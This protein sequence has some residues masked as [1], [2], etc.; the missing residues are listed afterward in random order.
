MCSAIV[1]IKCWIFH[2]EVILENLIEQG[3]LPGD[4]QVVQNLKA[5]LLG[6]HEHQGEKKRRTVSMRG[7]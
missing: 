4:V 6:A 5:I 3:H 1:S 2:A 7:T